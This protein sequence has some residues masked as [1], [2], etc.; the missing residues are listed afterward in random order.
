MMLKCFSVSEYQAQN[1]F[2]KITEE[3]DAIEP[4]FPLSHFSASVTQ[5]PVTPLWAGALCTQPQVIKPALKVSFSRNMYGT[6]KT[7]QL[8]LVFSCLCLHLEIMMAGEQ[9]NERKSSEEEVEI[10]IV[11]SN[12]SFLVCTSQVNFFLDR[13]EAAKIHQESLLVFFLVSY[14]LG[15]IL[16]LYL[17]AKTKTPRTWVCLICSTGWDT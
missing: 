15:K 4:T 8:F 6:M 17:P 7:S 13:D 10:S 12:L 9:G 3:I 14:S 11:T 5:H 16:E 1:D 2:F